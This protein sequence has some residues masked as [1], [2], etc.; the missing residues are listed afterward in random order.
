MLI[1]KALQRGDV[2]FAF[3]HG[4]RVAG[5]EAALAGGLLVE[6]VMN[7]NAFIVIEF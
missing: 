2:G 1:R 6:Y 4:I 5:V 3:V 7:N